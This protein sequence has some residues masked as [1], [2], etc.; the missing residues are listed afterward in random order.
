MEEV[1]SVGNIKLAHFGEPFPIEHCP[2]CSKAFSRTLKY[3][4]VKKHT[5]ELWDRE[6]F[7]GVYINQE[8]ASLAFNIRLRD[9]DL[10]QFSFHLCNGNSFH[11][12]SDDIDEVFP[13]NVNSSIRSQAEKIVLSVIGSWNP[14]ITVFASGN[15]DNPT[16][17]NAFILPSI[18]EIHENKKVPRA[19]CRNRH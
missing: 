10:V 17:I 11:L 18:W 6:S 4:S 1:N 3:S 14:A 9:E 19:K 7:C 2:C 12:H 13:I 15:P 8:K 16:P 5:S